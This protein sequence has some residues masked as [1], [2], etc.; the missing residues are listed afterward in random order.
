MAECCVCNKKIGLL[1]GFTLETNSG[2]S[3]L[4][5]NACI[6]KIWDLRKKDLN[7]YIAL[8]KFFQTMN[9]DVKEYIEDKWVSAGGSTENIEAEIAAKAKAQQEACENAARL[10]DMKASMLLTTGYN[11]EDYSIS[12]YIGVIS[13]ESVLG[14]GFL[15]E[16]KAAS[17]DI[18]GVQSFSFSAKLKLAKNTAT[19]NLKDECIKKGGNA[20]IGV[21][22][23]YLTFQNNMIGVIANGTA[24]II[25][26][27]E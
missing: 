20:I 25:E 14:T 23:D 9:P 27:G 1:G 22:F 12:K 18:F 10:L 8:R 3:Y 13:G 16:L 24:V 15:S 21:D 17:A 7:A 11:F 5:C 19:D 4:A 2:K 26:K 6:D